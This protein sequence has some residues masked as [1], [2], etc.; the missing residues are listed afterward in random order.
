MK[1]EINRQTVN[2]KVA[3]QVVVRAVATDAQ[4]NALKAAGLTLTPGMANRY[5]VL[6]Y[7]PADL[8]ATRAKVAAI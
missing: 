3:I 4:C 1:F 6:C 7:T 5:A 2:G 8:D